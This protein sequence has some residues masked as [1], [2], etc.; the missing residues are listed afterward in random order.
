MNDIAVTGVYHRRLDVRNLLQRVHVVVQ[1]LEHRRPLAQD[2]VAAE[3]CVFFDQVEDDV[4]GG[5]AG[6]VDDA[7][8]GALDEEL[9]AV[10]QE[11]NGGAVGDV[12]AFGARVLPNLSVLCGGERMKKGWRGLRVTY[13]FCPGGRARRGGPRSGR[14]ASGR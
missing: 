10:F 3:Y 7:E 8:G 14:G 6:G 11:L 12:V 1:I 9:L 4:V 2:A 5:V 13:L